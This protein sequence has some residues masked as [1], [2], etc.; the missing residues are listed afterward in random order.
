MNVQ[1]LR[2]IQIQ[3]YFHNKMSCQYKVSNSHIKEEKKLLD[4][5]RVPFFGLLEVGFLDNTRIIGLY[6]LQK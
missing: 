3:I 1:S 5:G 2:D 4:R 6:F